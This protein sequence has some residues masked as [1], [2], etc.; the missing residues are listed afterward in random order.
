MTCLQLIH[1]WQASLWAI[2]LLCLTGGVALAFAVPAVDEAMGGGVVPASLVGTPTAAQTV[3]ST[4]ATAMMTPITLVLTVT[5]LAVQV[6]MGQF[7]P[8]RASAA[9]G[10]AEPVRAPAVPGHFRLRATGRSRGYRP[11]AH[12][13]RRTCW[14]WRAL[15][16]WSSTFIIRAKVHRRLRAAR[17]DVR[18]VAPAERRPPLDRQ[19]DVLTAAASRNF[20]DK[21]DFHTPHWNRITKA[22]APVPTSCVR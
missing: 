17:E 19:L 10:S 5:T 1:A 18:A 2:P 7:S 4:V 6:A 8:R 20:E 11:R 3:L 13:G 14:C 21:E 9:A 22:S 16:C 15:S 12:R